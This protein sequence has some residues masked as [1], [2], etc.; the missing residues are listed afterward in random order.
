MSHIAFLPARLSCSLRLVGLGLTR[1]AVV[2]LSRGPPAVTRR[3]GNTALEHDSL[4]I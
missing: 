1:P 2:S 4:Q 3:P